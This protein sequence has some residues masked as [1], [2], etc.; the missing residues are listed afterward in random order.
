MWNDGPSGGSWT[1]REVKCSETFTE[2]C[3]T[4]KL[5]SLYTSS[6]YRPVLWISASR[7][8]VLIEIT[9]MH[10]FVEWWFIAPNLTQSVKPAGNRF[11]L[12]CCTF[13]WVLSQCDRITMG[14]WQSS[15]QHVLQCAFRDRQLQLHQVP[16]PVQWVLLMCYLHRERVC[17]DVIELVLT[18][19]LYVC[20]CVCV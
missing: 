10:S 16:H 17:V 2:G 3:Q 6:V 13:Q 14:A 8:K 19:G 9:V 1:C 7:S 18:E 5:P 15:E 11:C 12:Q 4:G 20:I